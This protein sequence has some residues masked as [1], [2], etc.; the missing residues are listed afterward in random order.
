MADIHIVIEAISSIKVK[1]LVCSGIAG[2]CGSPITLGSP[3]I[4]KQREVGIIVGIINIA[5]CHSIQLVVEQMRE[6]AR[7]G[8]APVAM[9]SC[10]GL[11]LS[12]RYLLRSKS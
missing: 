3:D 1:G 5:T 2:G 11:R 6:L 10:V 7:R 9:A 4:T 12:P 8:K